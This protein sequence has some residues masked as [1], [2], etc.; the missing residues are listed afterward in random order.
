[1]ANSNNQ[2]FVTAGTKG[3]YIDIHVSPN[4]KS[5]SIEGNRNGRLRVRIASP[6]VDGKANKELL[7]FLVNWLEVRRSE[8]KLVA[9][10][11]S[12]YK[13]LFV[14]TILDAESLAKKLTYQ[15]NA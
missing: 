4:A 8:I 7:R 14:R 15:P 6:P 11:K 9:G 10:E 1:M 13:R 2:D 3:C 12:K 5:T